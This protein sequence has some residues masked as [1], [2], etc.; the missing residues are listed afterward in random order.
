MSGKN[1]L[2][3]ESLGVYILSY[4]FAQQDRKELLSGL[5][6]TTNIKDMDF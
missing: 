2:H 5:Y 3:L 1:E 4:A 6:E